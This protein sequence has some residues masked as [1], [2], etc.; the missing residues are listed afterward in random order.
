MMEQHIAGYSRKHV[1]FTELAS[2]YLDAVRRH[3]GLAIMQSG[4]RKKAESVKQVFG[5]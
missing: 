5:G 4:T 2:S 3:D 1:N